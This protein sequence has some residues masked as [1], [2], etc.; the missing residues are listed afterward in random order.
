M[1]HRKLALAATTLFVLISLDA[2]ATAPRT[3]VASYGAPTNTA[4]NCSIIK[5]CRAFSDAISVT[6]TGGV[7]IVLESAGYG[8]FSVT[9]SITIS[10]PAGVYAGV[11]Q[12]LATAAITV[13]ATAASDVVR[14]RGLTV[15]GVGPSTGHGILFASGG[16][17]EL[18]KVE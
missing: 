18:E 11:T 3:F 7:V 15:T 12:A 8:P 10:T 17:L 1:L 9:K 6:S 14:L 16:M 5:P 2:V 13:A 4:F